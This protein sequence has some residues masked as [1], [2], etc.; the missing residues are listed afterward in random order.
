ML[1]TF[2]CVLNVFSIRNN[3]AIVASKWEGVWHFKCFQCA[4]IDYFYHKVRNCGMVCVSTVGYFWFSFFLFRLISLRTCLAYDNWLN[5]NMRCVICSIIWG[6]F[7]RSRFWI[8]IS[9]GNVLLRLAFFPLWNRAIYAFGFMPC[10]EKRCFYRFSKMKKY[11]PGKP[12]SQWHWQ[13]VLCHSK[14]CAFATN[15]VLPLPINMNANQNRRR[16]CRRFCFECY[17]LWI[18]LIK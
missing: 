14:W 8:W 6:L 11:R 3:S 10:D 4:S 1:E 9:N 13:K 12:L 7:I 16:Y 2:H 15:S 17:K 5:G 18:L